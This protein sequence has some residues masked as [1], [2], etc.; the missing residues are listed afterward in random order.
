VRVIKI[1]VEGAEWSVL[2]GMS[3]TLAQ[4]REDME[5]VV[6]LTPRWLRLQGTSAAAVIRHMHGQGFH[7][8]VLRE[9]YEITRCYPAQPPP[10]PRRLKVGEPLGCEQADVIFSRIDAETL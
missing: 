5:V 8:Y 4:A 6:E 10:R 9:E 3:L 1:D 7:A 2:R